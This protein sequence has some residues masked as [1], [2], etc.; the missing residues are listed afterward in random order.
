M[1][2]GHLWVVG[3]GGLVGRQVVAEGSTAGYVVSVPD[4][5]WSDVG[6]SVAAL[7]AQL[8][9]F[10]ADVT[11]DWAIAWCAGAGV[12]ATSED[13]LTQ[14]VD[15]HDGALR[16]VEGLI[17]EG[18]LDP[19]RGGIFLASSAGGVHA[20]SADP[21]FTEETPVAPLVPYGHAK[22][23]MEAAVRGLAERTGVR[24]F[25]G[26]LA[27][28]YGPGQRLD[29]AQGLISTICVADA[30]GTPLQVRVS[31]D[32]TR[33]YL[34]S[35]DAA[36]M[37]IAGLERLRLEPAGA[38]VTKIICS[39][40]PVTVGHL[41]GE[42][43]RVLHRPLRTTVLPGQSSGQV[44]DLRFTSMVWPEL[45]AL[46]GTTVPAGLAEAAADVRSRIALAGADAVLDPPR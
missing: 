29:K 3:G 42:S 14:E 26:R 28:I 15:V 18:L 20:G 31:L 37:V 11:G 6:A 22:V 19:A 25:I 39:G 46:A 10:A 30:L 17:H 40:Q 16:A 2:T 32:T 33:D 45:D 13:D 35:A 27:N 36:A 38:V 8:R 21:P 23:A 9:D 24:A 4:T 34:H 7:E 44:L 41:I 1:T 5:P 12:V 43:R